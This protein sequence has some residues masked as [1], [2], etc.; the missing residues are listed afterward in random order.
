MFSCLSL[1]NIGASRLVPK[2]AQEQYVDMALLHYQKT[3]LASDTAFTYLTKVRGI[4]KQVAKQFGIGFGDRSLGAMLPDVESFDGAMIRGVLQRFGFIKPNGREKFWGYLTVPI[5]DESG[6]LV[7]IY[8][9]RI[10]KYLKKNSPASVSLQASPV[11]VFNAPCLNVF[12]S[13]I[14]CSSPIETLS[15]LSCG[16]ENVV[17]LMGI[18]SVNPVFATQ[19][20]RNGVKHVTVGFANTP[21]AQRYRVLVSKMLRAEG[22]EHSYLALPKGADINN[23]YV[24]AREMMSLCQQLGVTLP[25]EALC[26]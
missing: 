18:S 8:G 9:R 24:K 15:L 25:V 21:Q 20:K 17:G 14:L 16:I 7:D 10:A 2:Q 13:V 11:S 23:V 22:I 6:V 3:L 26:H 5:R 12:D 1:Q 4:D 19:L